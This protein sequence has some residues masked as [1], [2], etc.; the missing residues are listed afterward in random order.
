MRAD[1]GRLTK[2]Y[3]IREGADKV[4]TQRPRS[5]CADEGVWWRMEIPK[6]HWVNQ[7]GEY[8]CVGRMSNVYIVKRNCVK[9]KGKG[10]R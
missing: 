5:D 9:G 7:A 4:P 3:S 2:D 6:V 10:G 8:K 1:W